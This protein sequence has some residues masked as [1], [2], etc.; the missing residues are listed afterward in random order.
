M[1][2]QVG[3][4]GLQCAGGVGEGL[5]KIEGVEFFERVETER[6]LLMGVHIASSSFIAHWGRCRLMLVNN[7]LEFFMAVRGRYRLA[8][9][10]AA[11]LFFIAHWDC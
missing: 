1:A 5:E 10:Y 3:R 4:D 8:D 7:A 9:L 2:V 6:L 11:S